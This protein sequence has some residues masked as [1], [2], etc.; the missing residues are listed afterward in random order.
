MG[1]PVLVMFMSAIHKLAVAIDG[2]PPAEEALDTAIVLAHA[3]QASVTLVGVVPVPV[4]YG[5]D[6]RAAAPVLEANTSFFRGLLDAARAK[7][8]AAGIAHVAVQMFEGSAPDQILNYLNEARPA[9]LVMGARGLSGVR[10]LLV[11]SVSDSVLHHA[12]CSVLI[13]RSPHRPETAESRAPSP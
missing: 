12:E 6:L 4:V 11:G 8:Q 2:S 13:V 5:T 3:T 9:L 10:R 7:V 1:L